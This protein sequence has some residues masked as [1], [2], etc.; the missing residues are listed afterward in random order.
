MIKPNLMNLT[1]GLAQ[2]WAYR[3]LERT[4]IICEGRIPSPAI[5][6]WAE[7]EANEWLA[8]ELAYKEI[9]AELPL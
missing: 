6:R 8:E 7:K 1:W 2:E 5:M 3:V 4:A 9:D